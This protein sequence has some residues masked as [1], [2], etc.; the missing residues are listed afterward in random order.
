MMILT[1]LAVLGTHTIEADTDQP[2]VDPVQITE[3][4]YTS[5]CVHI[6]DSAEDYV[7][8]CFF[9]VADDGD[10]NSFWAYGADPHG[11]ALNWGWSASSSGGEAFTITLDAVPETA[12]VSSESGG[13]VLDPVF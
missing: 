9:W 5:A 11:D 3:D 2:L 6:E 8:I 10:G 12:V 7:D 1:L 13:L 4:A